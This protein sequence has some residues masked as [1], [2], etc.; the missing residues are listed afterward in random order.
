MSWNLAQLTR[1]FCT[2]IVVGKDVI[3]RM[4]FNALKRTVD[5]MVICLARC[6]I[7]GHREALLGTTLWVC[8]GRPPW[9][10]KTPASR[11]CAVLG[12]QGRGTASLHL[13]P[14]ETSPK[15][16]FTLCPWSTDAGAL[17]S[18]Y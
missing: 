2:S 16:L 1:R 11:S 3:S 4:S 15:N 7:I 6:R 12:I 13:C 14:A 10:G 9:I 17:N 8:L 18:L 5:E